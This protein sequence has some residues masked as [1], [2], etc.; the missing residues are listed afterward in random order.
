MEAETAAHEEGPSGLMEGSGLFSRGWHKGT[1]LT[2]GVPPQGFL[3][4]MSSS[5]QGSCLNLQRL[6]E[7]PVEPATFVFDRSPFHMCTFLAE[8][9]RKDSHA[10][11]G[12]LQP[13]P[14]CD[15]EG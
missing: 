2:P 6:S 9:P 12:K 8:S 13:L 15:W 7:P 10:E 14:V 1:S 4:P 11:R 5:P 3:Q